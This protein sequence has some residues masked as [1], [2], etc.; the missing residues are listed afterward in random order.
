M[1]ESIPQEKSPRLLVI[2]N[3]FPPDRGGGAAVFG[4]LCYGL[5]ARGFRVT[6]RCAYPYYPEWKNKSGRNGW[7]V[8]RYAEQGVQVERYGLYIPGRPDSLL[9]RLIHEASFLLS[10]LR[11]VPASRRFDAVMVIC[12]TLSSVVIGA[13]IRWIFRRPLWL[14]VQ[15]IPVEAASSVALLQSPWLKKLMGAIQRSLFNAADV[16]STISPIMRERLLPQTR[17]GQPVH[18]LPNWL[19]GEL[20]VEIE[21]FRPRQ[22]HC[23]H[24]PVR[25]LYGGNLGLKQNLLTVLQSLQRSD[26]AFDFL[27]HGDGVQAEVIRTWIE[28]TGDSRFRFGAFLPAAGFARALFEADYFVITEG[29][30][31]GGSFMPSKLV[32]AL[33]AGTPVLT[34]SDADSPLGSEVHASQPGPWFSWAQLGELPGFLSHQARDPQRYLQWSHNGLGRAKTLS[35]QS[36]LDEYAA[37]LHALYGERDALR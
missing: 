7:R 13:L 1:A 16:W 31:A 4:D 8:W 5:A 26:V 21:R 33:A 28:S 25:L 36:L 30:G 19:D 37:K 2:V 23:I 34:I 20:A 27:I 35:R 17:R 9:P 14:N 3:N 11:S 6:A 32:T 29:S 12:P 24:A 15:D 18:L 10:L 22:A